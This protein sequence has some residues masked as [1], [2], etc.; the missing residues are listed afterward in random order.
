LDEVP[1]LV[2]FSKD[3]IYKVIQKSKEI[4]IYTNEE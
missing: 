2:Y 3:K 4:H 1:I